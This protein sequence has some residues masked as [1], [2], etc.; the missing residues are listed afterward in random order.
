MSDTEI[1]K[2]FLV[3]SYENL[4]RLDLELIALEKKPDDRD[5]LASIFRTIHTIKGTSGFL[6]FNQLQAVAHAGE[7]LLARLRDGQLALTPEITTTLLSMVDAVRQMLGSIERSGA[8]GARNDQELISRLTALL[9]ANTPSAVV[10]SGAEKKKPDGAPNSVPEKQIAPLGDILVE[11]GKATPG[12]VD[13]ALQQQNEGDPRHVGE[14]LVEKGTIKTQ[15]VVDALNVQQQVRGQSASD[16]TIRVDVG[17]LDRLMNRVGELV[18]LR[19]QIVQYRVA[20]HQPAPEPAHY[21][22]TGKRDEDPHAADWQCLEQVSANSEGSGA[23]LRQEGSDPDGG[24]GDR[25][26]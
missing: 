14:I 8:E 25:T 11:H 22:I 20:G 16:S 9:E 23:R 13:E 10:A 18:L 12:D 4:D 6:A 15:D 26:R 3:E 5:T 21:R 2:E 19:N 17:Q 24:R 1:I 7:S